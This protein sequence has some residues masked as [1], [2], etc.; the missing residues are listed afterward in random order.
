ANQLSIIEAEEGNFTKALAYSKQAITTNEHNQDARYNYELLQ[1]YLLLHPEKRQGPPPTQRN[2]GNGSQ[3][4]SPS[5]GPGNSLQGGNGTQPGGATPA[6][7]PGQNGS[8]QQQARGN[9]PGNQRGQSNAT[10][11]NNPNGRNG[12]GSNRPGGRNDAVLQTRYERLQKLNLTPEKARQLL[13]A[14]RQE[15]AQYLQ[16]LPRRKARTKEDDLPDW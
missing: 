16:Q 15:E 8:D 2:K 11:P 4:N 5:P 3:R 12:Q 9:S 14:M 13:D 10:D 6:P 1:K 7:Q